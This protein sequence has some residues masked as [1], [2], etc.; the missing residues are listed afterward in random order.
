MEFFF[1][2]RKGA[3]GFLLPVSYA[4]Q[5]TQNLKESSGL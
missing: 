3:A 4:A 5:T 2:Y 1:L